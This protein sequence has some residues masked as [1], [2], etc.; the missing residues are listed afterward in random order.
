MF[1]HIEVLERNENTIKF[2]VDIF[3]V[4][5]KNWNVTQQEFL[6]FFQNSMNEIATYMGG[7]SIIMVDG[8]QWIITLSKK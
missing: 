5:E 7:T 2:K 6:E 1:N 4:D 3:Q 8:R